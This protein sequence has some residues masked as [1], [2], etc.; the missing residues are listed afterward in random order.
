MNPKNSLFV[1][2][3]SVSKNTNISAPLLSRFDLIFIMLDSSN[4]DRDDKIASFLLNHSIQGSGFGRNND[5]D[6]KC[7]SMEKLRAYIAAVKERFQPTLS[8]EAALLLQRH[9]TR[10]R[11]MPTLSISITVRFLE[12][13]IRLSQAHARLMYRNTVTLQDAA[14][15]ILIMES[16]AATSGGL[17]GEFI[18][19]KDFLYKPPMESNFPS[20]EQAD[21]D[22]MKDQQ[23]VIRRYGMLDYLPEDQL[24]DWAKN[25]EDV[26]SCAFS[27]N[28]IHADY[29]GHHR[30][31]NQAQ[32]KLHNSNHDYSRQ[33]QNGINPHHNTGD[34]IDCW[35]RNHSSTQPTGTQFT[36]SVEST[37]TRTLSPCRPHDGTGGQGNIVEQRLFIKEG[38]HNIE[39]YD[40]DEEYVANLERVASQKLKEIKATNLVQ[41][42]ENEIARLINI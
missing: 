40:D 41:G 11:E 37:S 33:P 12:S 7:W 18:D 1:T 15:V 39:E 32:D 3:D 31:E 35:G 22:F 24:R 23:T 30:D 9:Y 13:L 19:P 14:A 28:S 17:K 2:E 29:R 21:L 20:N 6:E 36:Q 26:S 42:D 25:T 5:K 8:P 34:R 10:C 4:L 38:I 27:P 16:S